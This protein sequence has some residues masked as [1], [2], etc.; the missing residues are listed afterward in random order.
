MGRGGVLL[1]SEVETEVEGERGGGGGGG[2]GKSIF[3][4]G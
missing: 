3:G 1:Y 4:G 2:G